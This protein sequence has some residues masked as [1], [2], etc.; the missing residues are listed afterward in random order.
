ML[1][2]DRSGDLSIGL[3]SFSGLLEFSLN[4]GSFRPLLPLELF[5]FFFSET[6]IKNID[7]ARTWELGLGPKP[8][9]SEHQ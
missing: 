8:R 9:P 7:M 6:S 3:Q 1:P 2:R 4:W 5:V